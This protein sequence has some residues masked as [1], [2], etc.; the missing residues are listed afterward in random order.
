MCDVRTTK[1]RHFNIVFVPST[2]NKVNTVYC[3][4]LSKGCMQEIFEDIKGT[5]NTMT[6]RKQTLTNNDLQSTT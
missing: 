1:S 4:V 3:Y 6:K 5:D 2:K